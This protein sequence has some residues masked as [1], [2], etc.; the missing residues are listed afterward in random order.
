[1][2][3][4]VQTAVSR[5]SLACKP[6]NTQHSQQPVTMLEVLQHRRSFSFA[7]G[8]TARASLVSA[9]IPAKLNSDRYT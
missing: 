4:K 7:D 5:K 3:G 9:T 1:M 2:G 8:L 6:A